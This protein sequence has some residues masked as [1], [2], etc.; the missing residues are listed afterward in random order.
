[1]ARAVDHAT[2]GST[3]SKTGSKKK[4]AAD[5]DDDEDT[6]PAKRSKISY[7]RG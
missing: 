3:T 1:M 7:G 2:P 5:K 6:K 4:K